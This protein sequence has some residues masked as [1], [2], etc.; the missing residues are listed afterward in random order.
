[1]V[2]NFSTEYKGLASRHRYWKYNFGALKT[3]GAMMTVKKT[4]KPEMILVDLDSGYGGFKDG[5][6]EKKS[7]T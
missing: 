6:F 7:I 5:P 4:V 1:M 3:I 2:R